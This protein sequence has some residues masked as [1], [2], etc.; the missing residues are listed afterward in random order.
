MLF[1]KVYSS[2]PND[3]TRKMNIELETLA[4]ELRELSKSSRR[5]KTAQLRD[6]FD[7]IESAKAAGVSNKVIVETLQKNGIFFD[8]N[9]FKNA[10]S[11]ILKEREIAALTQ[12]HQSAVI[13]AK[14]V[15]TKLPV[16]NAEP[17]NRVV[18]DLV[19]PE[20]ITDA[21]WKDMKVQNLVNKHKLNSN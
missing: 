18:Q 21:V 9:N 15:L 17:K 3:C 16:R 5:N 10:R 19:R 1:G 2:K 11:R 12:P 14:P 20:G 6:I 7:E 4:T 8:V 13:T